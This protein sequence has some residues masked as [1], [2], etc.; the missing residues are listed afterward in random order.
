MVAEPWFTV[1]ESLKSQQKPIDPI[2]KKFSRLVVTR[3]IVQILCHP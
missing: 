1:K 3:G 2:A